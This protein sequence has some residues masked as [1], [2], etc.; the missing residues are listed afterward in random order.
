MDYILKNGLVYISG[1]FVKC[2]LTI[3]NGKVFLNSKPQNLSFKVID[4]LNKHIFPGFIDVHTHLREP[5]FSYKETIKTG[6]EA[7]A[8][9]GYCALF[10]MPNLKP[11]PDCV[12]NL[13][14]QQ[15]II[16]KDAVIKVYPY[17]SITEGQKG[18][19]L[20]DINSLSKEVKGFSDDGKGVQD[21]EMME[22]AM[23]LA[24]Q[25]DSII[26]AHCE[27]EKLL[28]G[29]YIHDGEYAKLNGHKGISSA[30]EYKQVQRDLELAKRVGAKYHICHLSAK[31]SVEAIRKAKNEGV[32][33]T[34]E[35]APHYLVL[36]DM[37]L[38]DDGGFKM[39]PP[40][41]S[42]EDR[43]SL[44]EGI[45][46]GTIDMLATDHA[47]HS[48]E[49]KSKGL[50]SLNGIVGLETAFPVIYTDLVKKNIISLEKVIEI[51]SI[52]PA[53]RFSLPIGIE[54]GKDA[55]LCV[56]D[57]EKEYAIEPER[58]LSKGKSTPFKG[59][60]VF[61]KCEYNFVDGK[62]VYELKNN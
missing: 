51:M 49:E 41:R 37:M 13:R 47:P 52:N 15:E 46:D 44:I 35:T 10:S 2:D 45:L 11:V 18:E 22:D 25:N 56:Y 58:F 21:E 48:E 59:K 36:N 30:S 17:A 42:E 50:K 53:K 6:T 8:S 5:G 4:C 38:I 34:A 3:S 40:I 28:D 20:V 27:D 14:I 43:L 39:N 55:N 62:L 29:G 31:E 9:A 16:D 33:V 61:G 54:D 12:G 19:H 7:G 23:R 32:D 57:L 24:K 26:V 60:K 1:R